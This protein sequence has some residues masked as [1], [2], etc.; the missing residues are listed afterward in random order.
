MY[1]EEY[2]YDEMVK[3]QNKIDDMAFNYW[4]HDI[5]CPP[6]FLVSIRGN[7]FMITIT[8]LGRSYTEYVTD[9]KNNKRLLDLMKSLY[10]KTM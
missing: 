10:N 9:V 3:L 2:S 5:E 7:K 4:L 8:H 6:V 1:K